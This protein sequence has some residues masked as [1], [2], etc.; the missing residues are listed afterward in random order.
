MLINQL[1]KLEVISQDDYLNA[2]KPVKYAR[3]YSRVS[4][5]NDNNFKRALKLAK[6]NPN[7]WILLTNSMQ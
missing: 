2:Y 4:V 5:W 7:S 1:E 6:E 3:N